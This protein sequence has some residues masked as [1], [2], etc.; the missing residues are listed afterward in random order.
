MIEPL[1]YAIAFDMDGVVFR[2]TKPKHDAMLGLF[3]ERMK[4]VASDAIMG[5]SGVA[6]KQK[7][8]S[9][10]ETCF[11]RA[12]SSAELQGYLQKYE[13]ALRGVL[14]NPVVTPGIKSFL[15]RSPS[16]NFVCSSAPLDEVNRQLRM[17]GLEQHFEGTYG[18]PT[19]K[20]HALQDVARRVGRMDVVFFGDAKVDRD[21]AA[22][23]GCA[24]VAVVGETDQFPGTTAPKIA[25]FVNDEVVIEA[26]NS[27]LAANATS[28][29]AQAGDPPAIPQ[30]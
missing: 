5:M 30:N 14:A 16:R 10:Y 26:I 2:T 21:A 28:P 19:S 1:R 20:T 3:P 23:A 25:D 11:G 27:A 15:E 8:A 12:P 24:F 18:A 4:E 13:V 9:V 7:L 6:R 29:L 22:S 17:T